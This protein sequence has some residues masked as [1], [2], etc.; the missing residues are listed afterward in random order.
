MQ[1]R[2]L[3]GVFLWHFPAG[4]PG[5]VPRPPR[6]A[7]SGLSSNAGFLSDARGCLT[8]EPMVGAWSGSA[9]GWATAAARFRRGRAAAA[10]VSVLGTARETHVPV[11]H[12][13]FGRPAGAQALPDAFEQLLERKPIA[14]GRSGDA[15]NGARFADCK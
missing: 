10:A 13:A 3:G 7:V 5:S 2:R 9:K 11:A 4:F 6:P 15:G 1:P 14:T 8:G 12:G